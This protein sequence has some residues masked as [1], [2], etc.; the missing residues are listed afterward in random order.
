MSSIPRFATH[1]VLTCVLATACLARPGVFEPGA[2]AVK[3]A[4]G[5]QFAEGP[6]ADPSGAIFFT[7]K[8][9]SI[10][11][12][13]SDTTGLSPWRSNSGGANSLFFWTNV[14]FYACEEFL[15]R[16]TS[17][18]M[19]HNVSVSVSTYNNKAFNTPNDLWVS[20]AGSV[21]F[22]HPYWPCNGSPQGVRA[23]YWL[24][25]GST[26]A[27]RVITTLQQPNGIPHILNVMDIVPE[28][29]LWAGP[30]S[31]LISFHRFCS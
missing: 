13:W 22:T 1:V 4:S 16:V 17:I 23:V 19:A 10:I 30:V 24:G 21:C 9:R 6:A 12:K 5:F 14:C 31:S 25:L 11:W 7:D 27:T 20:P 2:T 3:L 18:D 8:P 15:H 28:P 29:A 26:T